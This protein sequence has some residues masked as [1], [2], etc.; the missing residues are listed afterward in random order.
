MSASLFRKER[1][2]LPCQ[3][4][5]GYARSTSGSQEEVLH[6]AINQYVPLDNPSPQPG[7]ITLIAAHANGIGKELYEPLWDELYRA[8]AQTGSFRIRGIW[9]ADVSFQGESGVLNEHKLGNDRE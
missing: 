1:H 9:I 2:V 5:R 6:I 4:I 8:S 3:H 7:D